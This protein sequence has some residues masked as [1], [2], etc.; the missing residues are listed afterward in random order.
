MF[1]SAEFQD[2]L[3]A[4]SVVSIR[5]ISGEI[6]VVLG[7]ILYF[8]RDIEYDDSECTIHVRK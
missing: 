3:D 5:T 7:I 6:N 4:V 1:F 8:F 2:P